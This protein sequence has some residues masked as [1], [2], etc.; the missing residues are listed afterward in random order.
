[1]DLGPRFVAPWHDEAT[2]LDDPIVGGAHDPIVGSAASEVLVVL[3]ERRPKRYERVVKPV[4]DRA[5]ALV[6]LV[7]LSP[8]I[9][10]VALAVRFTLGAPVL[11]AQERV[12]QGGKPFTMWKFRTMRPDRRRAQRP[13]EGADR[14]RTHKS[15]DDPR[16][17][18][19]GRILRA[20]SLD[21]L[22]QL[23]NVLRGE[24]SLVGPRPELVEVVS[25][26]E[27]WQHRRH[28][29]RPGITGLWQVTERGDER[30]MHECVAIDLRYVARVA[31]RTDVWI[32]AMTLP[33]VLGLRRGH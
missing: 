14:R 19:L 24:L 16:H 31:F 20:Y 15:V 11:Y 2:T 7:V 23:W 10:L 13:F 4:L 8:L 22:P 27:E 29:V 12:G 9:A 6:L 26:Y 33:V 28:D 3:D 1:M 5:L 25:R 17:T 32:L 30:P 21:E 18:P